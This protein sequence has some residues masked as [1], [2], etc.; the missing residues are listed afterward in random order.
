MGNYYFLAASLPPLA[1]GEKPDLTFEELKER[2]RINLSPNDYAKTEVLRRFIDLQNIRSLLLEESI[3]LK[4]NL[5]E[6]E[7]D[8]AL[9]IRNLL[10]TYVFDFLDQYDSSSLRIKNFHGLLALFF[11][12]ETPKQA[13][14]LK[15]YLTFERE[16]RL[17]MMALRAKELGRDIVQELQFE[18]FSDPLVAQILAQKDAPHYD[19]PEEYHDLKEKLASCDH[20]PWFKQKVFAEYRFHKIDDL[21]DAPLFSIDWILAYLAKWMIVE[22]WNGLD[23]LKGRMI[24][25]TFRAL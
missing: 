22:Y 18:D 6:K 5:N 1:L 16:W 7:L 12:E 3:D 2:L 10:P 17:V 15:C 9:L 20:D 24:L 13:G 4:G 11:N 8:E 25:D 14:F 23:E 19:P 21:T